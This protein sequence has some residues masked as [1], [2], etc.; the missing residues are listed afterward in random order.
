M[1]DFFEK[2][3]SFSCG[4]LGA[5]AVLAEIVSVSGSTPR[6]PGARMLLTDDDVFSGTVGGGE[7]EY[8]A[9]AEARRVL[10]SGQA[11]EKTYSLG[12]REGQDIGMICGGTAVV[13]FRPLSAG[14]A[15]DLFLQLRPPSRVLIYGAGH[16]GKA[17]ADNL[18]LLGM[19]VVVTDD[20]EGLLTAERFPTAERRLH[21]LDD[22]DI[23]AGREDFVVIMTHG[24]RH[25]FALLRRA[26]ETPAAYIG[27]M[28]SHKKAAAARQT[29][30]A[31]G[32]SQE[33]IDSR[34]YSPIGLAIG[35]ETPEEIA[36]SI[37]AEFIQFLRAGSK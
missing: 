13:C 3:Q 33:E 25:D 17:L 31:D 14:D 19:P 1:N 23:D 5:R 28:A 9:Q 7:L 18:T 34:L 30:L 27:V 16:V 2:L 8:Q 26:L 11:A 24:H 20:R 21:A 6:G 35:A 37:A 10:L 32:F 4:K 29:L 36:V 12:G 22:A 15:R